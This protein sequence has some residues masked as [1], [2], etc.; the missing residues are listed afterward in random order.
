MS[1]MYQI[2]SYFLRQY[3]N[4][5]FKFR[6]MLPQNQLIKSGGPSKSGAFLVLTE[7]SQNTPDFYTK[8]AG[9]TWYTMV[10]TM[11]YTEP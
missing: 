3:F 7:N 11:I 6:E 2:I 8:S 10:Y 9:P 5:R 1:M 4:L